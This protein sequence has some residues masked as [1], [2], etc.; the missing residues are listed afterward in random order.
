MKRL[1]E[2]A[3]EQQRRIGDAEQHFAKCLT[4]Y[5][6]SENKGRNVRKGK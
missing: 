4:G 3:A 5:M 1:R 2:V 6:D